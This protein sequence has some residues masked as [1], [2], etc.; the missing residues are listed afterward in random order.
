MSYYGLYTLSVF[1]NVVSFEKPAAPELFY[2]ARRLPA[3]RGWRLA[4][5][6]LRAGLDKYILGLFLLPWF[7]QTLLNNSN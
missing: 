7:K 6:G 3:R 4:A 1:A 5:L 2:R